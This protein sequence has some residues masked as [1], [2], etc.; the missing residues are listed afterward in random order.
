[1]TLQHTSIKIH[2]SSAFFISV[3][4]QSYST[5]IICVLHRA[6]CHMTNYVGIV[7]SDSVVVNQQVVRTVIV[8]FTSTQKPQQKHVVTP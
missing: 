3:W 4:Q 8:K 6:R 2:D 7:C 5:R 1:M